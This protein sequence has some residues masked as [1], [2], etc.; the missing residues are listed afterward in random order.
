MTMSLT[1]PTP[2]LAQSTV[3]GDHLA[4]GEL[5]AELVTWGRID[6]HLDDDPRWMLIPMAS[7]GLYW[8]ALPYCLRLDVNFI[9]AALPRRI[10]YPM[11]D[12]PKIQ[13]LLDVGLWVEAD[14]GYTYDPDDWTAI[15]MPEEKRQEMAEKRSVA[16]KRGAAARWQTDGKAMAMPKQSY[17]KNAPEPEPVPVV[18]SPNGDSVARR[19]FVVWQE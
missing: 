9:P 8:C 14:G 2:W 11:Q 18:K 4:G 10:T 12:D 5:E 13:P 16:G 6:D 1:T 15:R 7:A 19:V 3:G 17:G